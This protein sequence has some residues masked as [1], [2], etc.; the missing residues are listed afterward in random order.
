MV[1]IIISY[2]VLTKSVFGIVRLGANVVIALSSSGKKS[3][4]SGKINGSMTSRA[5]NTKQV[6]C[7]FNLTKIE[8]Y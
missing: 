6:L 5:S 8:S 2:G 3:K 1:N 4:V 7:I